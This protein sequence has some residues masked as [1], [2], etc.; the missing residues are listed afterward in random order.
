MEEQEQRHRDDNFVGIANDPGGMKDSRRR[1]HWK[2][3]LNLDC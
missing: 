3:K 1:F 2:D